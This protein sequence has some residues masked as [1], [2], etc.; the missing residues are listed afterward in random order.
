MATCI[1]YN[2]C[3]YVATHCHV[4]SEPPYLVS[5]IQIYQNIWTPQIIYFNFV[6]IFGPLEQTF[7]MYL[8]PFEIFYLLEFAFNILCK[9]GQFISPEIF[10]LPTLNPHNYDYKINSYIS[11]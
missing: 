2:L 11:S 6:E 7:L 8:D 3:L 5:P 1:I 4:K 10:D 9:G